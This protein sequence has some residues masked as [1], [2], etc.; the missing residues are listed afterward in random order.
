MSPTTPTALAHA[1]R[2]APAQC[3]PR[4]LADRAPTWALA[5][6]GVLLTALAANRA[7]VALAGWLA[8]VPLALLATRWRGARGRSLLWAACVAGSTLQA[9]KIVT[10]PVGPGFAAAFGVPM[11]TV[12]WLTLVLWD[13]IRRRAGPA[14]GVHAFAALT[15]LADL[16]GARS[17]LGAWAISTASQVENLPLLQV[18][19][20]GGLA[21]VGFVMAWPIGGAVSLLVAPPGRRPWA[22]ALAAAAAVLLAHGWGAL[23]LAAGDDGAPTVRVAGVTVDFPARMTSIADLR[24]NVDALFARSALAAEAG[25]QLVAWNEVATVVEREEEPALVARGAAFARAHRVD[26]V[27]AYGVVASRAPLR[28]ANVYRWLGARGEEIETYGKHF[29]PPGEPS[30]RSRAPLAVHDRPWGRAAGAIC[31]DYDSPALARA[32]AR[33]GAGLVVLPSSDWR[34]IDPQHALMARVRA[35]EGGLSVV[36]PVRAATSMAFDPLGRVRASLPAREKN[37]HVLLATVPSAQIPTPYAAAGDWPAALAAALV[38]AASV[39]ALRR[40]GAGG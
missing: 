10:P 30:L 12:T 3:T 11:G 35:I 1:A 38:L 16:A 19:S 36:R 33:G 29:L 32:H 9:L 14:W 26:L 2:S 4:T 24:G 15:A 25:A 6:A 37:D 8:P 7:G 31:Y 27:M 23:R 13:A 39:A 5:A 40:R 28:I 34:G 22:H 17:P 21:L 18:A 20:L